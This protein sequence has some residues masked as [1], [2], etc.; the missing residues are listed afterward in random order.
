LFFIIA[1]LY[2]Y[3]QL[4][5]PDIRAL[6]ILS[7]V[8]LWAVRLA[9]YI[10]VRHWGHDE[11]HRYAV[12]R[13]NN[14]PGIEFK[15]LY[16]IYEIQAL[17][18]WIISLPLYYAMQPGY[19]PGVFDLIG[20]MLWLTGMYFEVVGDYQLWRFKREPENSGK[21]FTGGLWQYTRHPNYFGEFLIWWGFFSF[22]L[23]TGAY[24]TIISPLLMTFFLLKFSG[25]GRLETT[26][27]ERAGYK[28]YMRSTSAFFPC[29]KSGEQQ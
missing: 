1:G 22:A 15:S 3:S 23:S 5:E 9:A 18:A 14:E 20:L 26:M 25:V 11:D 8:I 28:H 16:L 17:M 21:I 10:T 2:I 13:A 29:F 27:R 19:L 24:W 12:I 7:L 6:T 4:E